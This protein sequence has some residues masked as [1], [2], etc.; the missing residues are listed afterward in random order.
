LE[1]N[2]MKK[3]LHVFVLLAVFLGSVFSIGM[4]EEV[5]PVVPATVDEEL[6]PGTFITI[7]KTVTTPVVPPVVDICLLQDETGSF[8]DDIENLQTAAPGIYDT[9]IATSPDAQ[10]AVAGFRDYPQSPYG[11][12]G[13]WV[14]RL[15]SS[16]SPVKE[17]WT[18]GVNALTASGGNDIPEAQ[19]DAIVAAVEGGFGDANCGWRADPNVQKVLVVAT[20]A[21][22][23]QPGLGKPHINDHDIDRGSTEFS[24]H[25]PDWVKSTRGR[26]GVGCLST[27][28]R[29]VSTG[30]ELR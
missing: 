13:D 18:T 16:M 1:E 28:H 25:P 23:H 7:D 2:K 9:I 26:W 27:R 5:A 19:Y 24:G 6:Y 30:L 21:P 10:F 17:N 4:A 22:F 3:I 14:Y 12:P 8:Y 15:V 20:D 11:S 29:R